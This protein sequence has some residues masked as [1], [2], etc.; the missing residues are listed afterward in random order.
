ME[1]RVRAQKLCR[2][3][4]LVDWGL[5]G[6]GCRIPWQSLYAAGGEV[7]SKIGFMAS[8][9]DFGIMGFTWTLK[10]LPFQGSLL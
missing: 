7:Q 1:L 3:F 10:N 2:V 6:S 4:S 9:S 5:E 8:G